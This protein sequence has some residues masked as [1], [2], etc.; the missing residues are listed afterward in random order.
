MYLSELQ[1]FF[2]YGYALIASFIFFNKGLISKVKTE[3][4][5]SWLLLDNAC[6]SHK[7]LKC[8]KQTLQYKGLTVVWIVAQAV[9]I[10]NNS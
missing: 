4:K 6:I 3:I 10:V 7:C 9:W 8:F 2:S 5:S 1:R